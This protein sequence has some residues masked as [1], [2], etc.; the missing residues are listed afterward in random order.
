MS[1]QLLAADSADDQ[2]VTP[3][4]PAP[5]TAPAEQRQPATPP[6]AASF[7]PSDKVSADSAVSFPSDI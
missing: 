7:T 5:M 2:Q 1:S 4:A 3:A 6:P